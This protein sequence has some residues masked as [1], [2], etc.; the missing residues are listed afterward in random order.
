VSVSESVGVGVSVGAGG[1]C[2]QEQNEQQLCEEKREKLLTSMEGT[3]YSWHQ[4]PTILRRPHTSGPL[5][6]SATP[7]VR[8]ED[9]LVRAQYTPPGASRVCE[10]NATGRANVHK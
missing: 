4:A 10:R 1:L 9:L 7:S 3:T 5:S 8:R 2:F 6:E